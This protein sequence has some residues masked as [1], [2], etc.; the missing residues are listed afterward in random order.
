[1]GCHA[2]AANGGYVW[3]SQDVI[4]VLEVKRISMA[5]TFDD[6]FHKL[7]VRERHVG[8]HM[9]RGCD[10]KLD[11]QPAFIA[12]ARLTGRYPRSWEDCQRL[13]CASFS[14]TRGTLTNSACAMGLQKFIEGNSRRRAGSESARFP[15]I[16]CRNNSLLK[17]NG[18]PYISPLLGDWW[19]AVVSNAENP[20]GF[21]SN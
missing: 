9:R 19:P 13:A 7:R 10:G 16:V 21:S 8:R 5:R 3:Q 17:M 6:A 14:A 20:Y 15:I 11:I 12:F 1:M 2:R 4:A 18:Q